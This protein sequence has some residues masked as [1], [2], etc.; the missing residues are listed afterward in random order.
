MSFN[1]SGYRDLSLV[2]MVW[3]D[4]RHIVLWP[5]LWHDC[6]V[7]RRDRHRNC[8]IVISLLDG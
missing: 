8:I 6:S 3:A 1:D 4:C 5:L 2:I 7:T